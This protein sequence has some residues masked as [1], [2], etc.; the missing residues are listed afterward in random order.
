MMNML[1][2]TQVHYVCDII[3]GLVFATWFHRNAT[4]AVL[5]MDKLLSLPYKAGK[6]IYENKCKDICGGGQEEKGAETQNN[7]IGNT[8]KEK[9][10]KD[11]NE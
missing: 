7:D 5:Y 11:N 3:G 9:K 6:W 8:R 1:L 10:E 4:R 2:I